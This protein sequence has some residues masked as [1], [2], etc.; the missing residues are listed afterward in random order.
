MTTKKKTSPIAMAVGSVLMLT[1][2]FSIVMH[3][4]GK[5]QLDIPPHL[6]VVCVVAGGLVAFY[7]QITAVFEGK[8]ISLPMGVKIEDKEDDESE[9][10]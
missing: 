7:Q 1:L 10:E 4:L 6:L 2:P 5:H 8:T 9:E 3:M